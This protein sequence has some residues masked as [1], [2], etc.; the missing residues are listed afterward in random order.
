[1]S[2][3]I[4]LFQEELKHLAGNNSDLDSLLKE[5]EKSLQ[6][7]KKPSEDEVDFSTGEIASYG[8]LFLFVA[9]FLFRWAKD[10]LDHRRALNE[11]EIAERRISII[12]ALAN[13]GWDK[14]VAENVT[15]RC[16][17]VIANRTNDDPV[18]KSVIETAQKYLPTG[19]ATDTESDN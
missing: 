19:N 14:E 17:E 12:N 15:N 2:Q 18:L 5:L 10:N 11:T 3:E 16:L 4:K 7:E 1:M 9:Y 6:D 8:F 13:D